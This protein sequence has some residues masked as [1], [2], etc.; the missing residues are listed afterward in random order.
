MKV[1]EIQY[2]EQT[3]W[4]FTWLILIL[5]DWRKFKHYSTDVVMPFE[6]IKEW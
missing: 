1:K 6:E 4:N 2:I 3:K 5:E